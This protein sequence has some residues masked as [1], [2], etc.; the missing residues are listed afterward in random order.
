MA[1]SASFGGRHAAPGLVCRVSE[2]TSHAIDELAAARGVR[3]SDVIRQM[4]DAELDRAIKRGELPK[5][6]LSRA[7]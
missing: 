3:R 1:K 6:V 4:V 5:E 7:S 2:A